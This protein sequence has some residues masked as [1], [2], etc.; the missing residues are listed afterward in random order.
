MS[1]SYPQFLPPPIV[2]KLDEFA[3]KLREVINAYEMYVYTTRHRKSHSR[4]LSIVIISDY[5]RGVEPHRRYSLV[6]K[7]VPNN[8]PIRSIEI[9]T[10]E[11]FHRKLLEN[12]ELQDVLS[13]SIVYTSS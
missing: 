3:Q 8:L 13:Y 5:F 1:I 10:Y 11:E 6:L 2:R 4:N 9:Y 12:P 7:L